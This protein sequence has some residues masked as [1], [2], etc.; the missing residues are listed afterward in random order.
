MKTLLVA[1]DFSTASHNG[2][3]YSLQLAQSLEARIVLF[4]AYQPVTLP[5]PEIAVVISSDELKKSAQDRLQQH[6]LGAGKAVQVPV[7][8]RCEEGEAVKAI[9]EEAARVKADLIITGVKEHGKG[10]RQLFGS[11]I[12]GLIKQNNIPLLVIPEQASYKQPGRIALASDITLETDTHTLDALITIGQCFHSKVYI[13]R[14]INNRFSE[15]LEL[16]DRSSKLTH[17]S[18][19]LETTYEYYKNKHITDALQEFV[20]KEHIDLLTLVP[21]Q[22]STIERLFHKSNTK[23]MIFKTVVPLLV[24]PEQTIK[25]EPAARQ[26]SRLPDAI[27]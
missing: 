20:Q 26:E 13:V 21:H 4:S 16:L 1:T 5:N 12:T 6:L 14:I 25:H 19:T 8:L 7:E 24:L 15:V 3:L 22:H 18:R 10:F 2:F 11:T 27:R 17:L 23:A 9:L